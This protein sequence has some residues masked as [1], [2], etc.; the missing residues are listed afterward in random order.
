MTEID[1]KKETLSIYKRQE[2][3]NAS[4]EYFNNDAL[5]A[6][7][8]VNKYAL[9]D[10]KGNIYEKTP[11]DM[12][13]RIASEFA[14]IEKKH[15]NPLSED[16]IYDLLKDFKYIVPQGSP[17]AGIGNNF[18]YVSLSNCFVI[19]NDTIS[20]SYG[21]ILKLDQELVQLMKRRA[22]VGLDLS[23]VRPKGSPVNNSAL[24]STGVV[25]FMERF[26]NSTR[27]VAQD[28]RR[29]ALMETISINHP[30]SEDFIDAK[31]EQGKVTGANVSVKLSDE[32]MEACMNN[33][34]FIQKYPIDSKTPKFTKEIDAKP[35]WDKI[36]SNAHK[37]AEP[38]LLFWDNVIR[39]SIPDCYADLG[40][41]TIS[42]NPCVTGD[43]YVA[44]AD[45]RNYVKIKD[46]AE[47]NDDVD[48][49]CLDDNNNIK[50]RKMRNPRITGY[51]EKIYKVNI[52]NGHHLKVTGNHKFRLTSGEYKMAKDLKPNDSLFIMTKWEASIDEVFNKSNS[53][54][55]D[56][57]WINT[58]K[59]RSN[60]SEHRLIFE[61]LNNIKIPKNHVIH[62]KDYNGLNNNIENLQLMSKKEHDHFHSK[63]MIG[64]KNPYHKM[65]DSWKKAFASKPGEENGRYLN[66][67]NE[68]IIEHAKI[69]SKNKGRRF[70]NN[71]WLE[72]AEKNSLPK[73]FSIFRKE[74]G[75]PLILAKKVA[76]ELN[77]DYISEDP[78]LVKRYKK[79]INNNYNAKIED[80]K[81]LVEKTCEM[82]ENSLWTEYNIRE[83][84]FCSK[85][86]SIL[87]VNSDEKINKLRLEKINNSYEN[88]SELTK[89]EQ[90]EVYLELLNENNKVEKDKWEKTCKEKGIPFRL[91]TKWG[92]KNYD[93][94]K[95]YASHFNHKVI[96]VEEIGTDT[97]YN[98]TVDEYHNFFVGK[99]EE[100]TRSGKNK[101]VSVN[102]KN[103]GEITL[104]SNDSC[105]L[106]AINLYSYVKFPFTEK[107]EFD[108]NLFEKHAKIAQ[109]LMDDLVE[110]EIEKVNKIIKKIKD[111]PEPMEVKQGELNLWNNIKKKCEL[112]RRT[113]LGIT[114]EGDMLAAL[115]I[116]YGSDEGNDF[117]ENVHMRLKHAA[118]ESSAIMAK[119]RGAFPMWD[120]K[121]EKDNPFLLR[122]KDE[123]P[124]LYKLLTKNGRR[125][126]ALLTIA[127]TGSVSLMT[128]TTSG[129]E[130]AF[131][132][133][134]M[135]RRKINPNDKDARIDF[136]DEVGDSWQEYPVFHHKFEVYLKQNGYDIDEVK[137]WEKKR[138]DKLIKKS[139]YHKATSN[140]VNWVKKV[141][142]QGRVQRH[143]DHSI[144]V[145]VNLPNDTSEEMV[146]KVYQTGY[147]WGCKGVTVYRDGSRSGVLVSNDEKEKEIQKIFEDHNAPKRPKELDA[148]VIKFQ[149]NHE[150]WI[151]VIGL[152]DG[153]PYEI[154]TGKL[155]GFGS[156]PTTIDKGKIVKNRDK[157]KNS[158]YDFIYKDKDG[159]NV[160]IEGLSRSFNKE[161]WNYAKLISGVL[162]HGMPLQY[163][164]DLIDSLNL[165]SDVITTWKNGVK[166]IIKRYIPDGTKVENQCPNNEE[167]CG[168]EFKEGCLS[169]SKCDFSKCG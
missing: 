94:V 68:Q 156:I 49:Y 159:Y 87:Y 58:S 160:T 89:K 39:E 18:Q 19:G 28:G 72:Y 167:D 40:F 93:E 79:A 128:Q 45:D 1:T 127:P 59:F 135:R 95:E 29:G 165:D 109:R 42:T 22:G 112:G 35:L 117:V 157:N 90:I 123:N 141:E 13:R 64:E 137:T 33:K 121:R 115:G 23:F 17:M 144:S 77:Y 43:T 30:D 6:E 50:I 106:T 26:S 113:G 147:K 57:R 63:D 155:E 9:K 146:S 2:A 41:E 102:N 107:A 114:A 69:L 82:C 27:E 98:G 47:I 168:L 80:N 73:T 129:I 10:S 55:Q 86:C 152:L 118:Y 78:R 154:F 66:V 54:S 116:R 108:Y 164:V 88:K 48:V 134:Y 150:K 32:F 81:V 140:D 85:S 7:V 4:L 14:R 133:S 136:V 96:N 100:K 142:M 101:W 119:E 62:H 91:N 125:N 169:C 122:I 44:V 3:I 11:D 8:W 70:S 166:R 75:S 36:I 153:R 38:G 34:K 52:E 92:F 104:C 5:A 124:K 99:F 149:N 83:K 110:L 161:Y 67:T 21:G 24:T 138:V 143:I 163:V 131:L 76:L 16:E 65:T 97:V 151:A 105:R 130:P 25:P 31:T 148:D 74:L 20:D 84:S 12:H 111:D 15:P 158:R 61:E 37:S 51:N 162:R 56:Y 145:T 126:I 120:K 132:V 60:K 139:P 103:C 46:L 71:E 53:K